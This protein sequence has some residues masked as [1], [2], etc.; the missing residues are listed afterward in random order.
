ME[1]KD[2]YKIL[3]VEKKATD[4]EIKRAYRKLAREL[5]PDMNPG[6]KRGE[7]RFKEINEAYEVL[8]DPE[9]RVKY[10]QLGS[11]YAQ[12]QRMGRDP[13]GF[14]FSQWFAGGAPGGARV[15]YGDLSDLFGGSGF[16]DFFGTIFG[17]PSQR[18]QATF[19]RAGGARVRGQDIEH[20][21]DIT[22][23]EA[24]SG[25][26]RELEK[27]GKRAKV[28]IPRGAKT[29]TKVR[30][31]GQGG[32]GTG[33]EAG[34]LFLVVN[35][36]PHPIFERKGDDLYADV[37]VDLYTAA[38]GGETRVKT[39]DGEVVLR[40]APESQTGQTIRLRGKG[41]PRLHE[42]ETFGDLYARLQIQIPRNLTEKERALF[43]ELAHLR[44]TK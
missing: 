13:S 9:K 32:E 23:E 16:S 43:A 34:D 19:R 6:D 5:H 26:T 11:S 22:L 2:Y 37:P 3:G 39:L 31:R 18:T 44:E 12:W 30:I 33:R 10:D 8:G 1:Y 7:E 27:D 40:I 4:K 28:K 25:A 38:L 24:Y 17:Q 21:V 15:E 36:L 35:V 41:M 14:D 20:P 42:P 29:G